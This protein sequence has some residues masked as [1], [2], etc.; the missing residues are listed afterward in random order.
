VI[1]RPVWNRSLSYFVHAS[2]AVPSVGLVNLL[3]SL[4]LVPLVASHYNEPGCNLRCEL[5]DYIIMES[6]KHDE[7]DTD[8]RRKAENSLFGKGV[9]LELAVLER[10]NRILLLLTAS[11]ERS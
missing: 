2:L 9:Q 8:S 7:E 6:I 1:R 5:S 3:F 10:P 4:I 11:I